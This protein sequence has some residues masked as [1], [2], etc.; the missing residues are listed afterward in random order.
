M[1]TIDDQ[2][3]L[4]AC[5]LFASGT[6]AVKVAAECQGSPKVSSVQLAQSIHV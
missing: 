1:P 5:S 2:T 6:P 4:L 3:K